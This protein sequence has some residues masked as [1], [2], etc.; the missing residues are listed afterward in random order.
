[1]ELIIVFVLSVITLAAIVAMFTFI[2]QNK[3]LHSEKENL[4][5]ELEK[6]KA[7]YEEQLKV[8]DTRQQKLTEWEQKLLNAQTELAAT[9][10]SLDNEKEN[11]NKL[12][13]EHNSLKTEKDNLLEE[14][15]KTKNLLAKEEEK[16]NSLQKELQAIKERLEEEKNIIKTEIENITQKILD[17]SKSE[18][19]ETNKTKLEDLLKP[20]KEKIEDFKKTVENKHS[21]ETQYFSSLETQIK[22]LAELSNNMSKEA[23]NLATALKGQTKIQGNWGEMQVEL[24][25]ERAGLQKGVTYEAQASYDATEGSSNKQTVQPD[26]VVYLPDNKAIVIDSKVTLNS[27]TDWFAA[28]DKEAQEKAAKAVYKSIKEHIKN[29]SKKNYERIYELNQLDFVLMFIPVES[30]FSIAISQD[31]NLFNEAF[32]KGIMLVTP[33]TLMAVLKTIGYIWRQETQQK[34]IEYIVNEVLK[35]YEKF[36]G[37]VDNMSDIGRSLNATV[38]KYNS[39]VKKLS[40]GNGNLI[41]RIDK[42]RQKA[43]LSTK[44]KLPENGIKQ[45]EQNI[46]VPQSD[47]K[48]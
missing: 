9:Q 15:S 10:S 37:F 32:E 14:L 27:L 1:M 26:F 30:A 45:I 24:L 33:T 44:K 46:I 36:V 13:S 16:N 38:D 40:E 29:L 19:T 11:F 6:V 43:Q 7:L 47:N 20:L 12:Q 2:K 3:S 42:I 25:L 17:R 35:L 34:E 18:I 31:I 48:E 28:E 21:K 5:A 23:E 8:Q 22:M 39:A 41:G 4:T